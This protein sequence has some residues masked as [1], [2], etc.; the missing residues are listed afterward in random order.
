MGTRPYRG[1]L[2]TAPEAAFAVAG[3][4]AQL[5]AAVTDAD[6]YLKKTLSNL[7]ANKKLPK[8]E[9][10]R[11]IE[12]FLSV[13]LPGIVASALDE[14]ATAVSL[15]AQE[16]PLKKADCNQST[17]V[18]YVLFSS[19]PSERPWVFLELKTDTSSANKKQALTYAARLVKTPMEELLKE[20]ETIK[21][22]SKKPEKYGALL[23]RFSLRPAAGFA[24]LVYLTPLREDA[25]SL[26]PKGATPELVEEFSSILTCISFRELKSLDLATYPQA[27]ALFRDKAISAIAPDTIR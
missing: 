26:L 23:E 14:R 1:H 25:H 19:T 6:A 7:V 15:V 11:A 24:R 16:F 21:G 4:S 20:V 8:Y 5:G 17:N 2:L 3:A 27:W 13:F 18:D 9:F 12:P 22:V 10:E